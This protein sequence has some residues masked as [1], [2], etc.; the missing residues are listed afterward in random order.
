MVPLLH[1]GPYEPGLAGR[2]KVYAV[3]YTPTEQASEGTAGL[4]QRARFKPALK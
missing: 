1:E 4:R 3:I 2:L